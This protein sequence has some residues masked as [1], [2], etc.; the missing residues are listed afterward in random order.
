MGQFFNYPLF[1]FKSAISSYSTCFKISSALKLYEA[2]SL[3][4][5]P[6]ALPPIKTAELPLLIYNIV[7]FSSVLGI[8]EQFSLI[9]VTKDLDLVGLAMQLSTL[10]MLV[11]KVVTVVLGACKAAYINQCSSLLRVLWSSYKRSKLRFVFFIL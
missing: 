9:M 4:Q 6:L 11:L 5:G 8:E 7:V 1:L 3:C 10:H 2:A